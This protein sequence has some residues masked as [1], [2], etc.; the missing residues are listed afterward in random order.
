MENKTTETKNTAGTAKQNQLRLE[1]VKK[2]ASRDNAGDSFLLEREQEIGFFIKRVLG[3]KGSSVDVILP[4]KI[5]AAADSQLKITVQV[6]GKR[7]GQKDFMVKVPAPKGFKLNTLLLIEECVDPKKGALNR[8]AKDI[9]M[10]ANGIL[11]SVYSFFEQNKDAA[12][13]SHENLFSQLSKYFLGLGSEE[14]G[15][16]TAMLLESLIQSHEWPR[17]KTSV[18]EAVA[19]M[20]SEGATT[21]KDDLISLAAS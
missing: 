4:V 1:A 14:K 8:Y 16:V 19:S 11:G 13:A 7:S 12:Q 5:T 15:F 10:E 17:V 18:A 21:M 2:V 6:S 20:D 3:A 9:A